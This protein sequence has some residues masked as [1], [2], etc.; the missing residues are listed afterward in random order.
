MSARQERVENARRL[1]RDGLEQTVKERTAELQSTNE[2]FSAEV[3]ERKR[4]ESAL[5]ASEEW[6]RTIFE[7]SSVPMGVTDL[8]GRHI[9]VNAAS[10]RVLGYSSEELRSLS[11]AE[12]T[13]EDD[14]D[15][16]L[17]MFD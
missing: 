5:R 6:W 11:I 17:P 3:E 16:T 12:L 1:A 2:S 14:R 8:D 9:V 10:E 4:T 7:T 13:H 15:K